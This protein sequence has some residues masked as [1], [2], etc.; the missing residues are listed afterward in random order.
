MAVTN[1]FLRFL[2]WSK[3]NGASFTNTLTLGHLENNVINSIETEFLKDHNEFFDFTKAKWTDKYA[4]SYF[5]AL[6]AK[7]VNSID[8]SSYEFATIIHDMNLPIASELHNKYT[9]IIDGGT[10]EHIF[11]FPQAIQNCMHCLKQGGHFIGI[12]PINNLMGHGLYQFSPDL[13]YQVFSEKNGFLIKGI[14]AV[15]ADF[16]ID[17]INWYKISNP[18][19]LNERVTLQNT[20]PTYMMVLA[21][22]KKNINDIRI[23]Q[24][25][26]QNQWNRKEST[27]IEQKMKIKYLLVKKLF[28]R[29]IKKNTEENLEKIAPLFFKKNDY[30]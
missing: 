21:E 11:N 8:I 2:L 22:K 14:F 16:S 1:T 29:I 12:S 7:I 20:K 15:A 25:D 4:D 13:Y 5:N 9:A 27:S 28:R 18:E 30:I 3:K 17:T 23:Y 19:K 26:Y 6:G 24:S 10:L